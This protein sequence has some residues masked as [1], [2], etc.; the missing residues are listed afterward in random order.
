MLRIHRFIPASSLV[1]FSCWMSSLQAE[2][3]DKLQFSGFARVIAGYLNEEHGT[4]LGYDDSISFTE[5]TLL[6]L[7]L[8]YQVMD[9]LSVT[10]Q[11]VARTADDSDSGIEWLYLTY[12]PSNAWKFKIGRQRTPIF[13]YSDIIDVGFAYPWISLPQQVYRG[14][15]F[16]TYEGLQSQYEYV[17]K[18]ISLGLEAYIGGIEREFVANGQVLDT[19][20]D[21]LRGIVGTVGYQGWN[22]RASY[23]RG[24]ADINQPELNAF[25]NQLRQFGFMQS[26]DSIKTDGVGRFYQISAF[27]EDVDYFFRTE[28]MQIKADLSLSPKTKGYFISGGL[29]FYPVSVYL[30]ISKDTNRYLQPVAEIPTGI[31][32]QL[33]ALAF[34]YQQTF[35]QS[36]DNSTLSYTAGIRWD[37]QE[38]LALKAEATLLKENEGTQGLFTTRDV[39]NFDGQ[40]ILYQVAMEW[41]F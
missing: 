19:D 10:G 27:Y 21:N 12:T 15:L 30:S 7:Q 37:W 26:A 28:L 11:A 36:Q 13:N 6:G 2:T 1:L 32:A 23:H 40:A 34:G 16:P 22:F 31:N 17:G 41:V 5:Q 14:F 29:N 9:N 25:S 4:F 24:H 8:D 18:N 38:N 33:D 20:I 35:S 39:N 3:N